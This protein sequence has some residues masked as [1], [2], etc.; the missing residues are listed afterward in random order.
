MRPSSF[1]ASPFHVVFGWR[2][3]GWRVWRF[4]WKL[5][6]GKTRFQDGADNAREQCISAHLAFDGRGRS[7]NY[8]NYVDLLRGFICVGFY[9]SILSV[10]AFPLPLF[11]PR[12]EM[13][14]KDM[15]LRTMESIHGVAV[16]ML[17]AVFR[18]SGGGLTDGK[19]ESNLGKT[20]Q[21]YNLLQS[22]GR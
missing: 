6:L 9:V 8:D 5:I 16:G 12:K 7:W 17:S 3:F 4:F 2:V 21:S 1:F 15:E 20:S 10:R 14:K 18:C 13:I 11:N 22:Q 19:G